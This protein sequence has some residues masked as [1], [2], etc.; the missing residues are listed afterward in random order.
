VP[1]ARAVFAALL[2]CPQGPRFA[3]GATSDAAAN[4]AMIEAAKGREQGQGMLPNFIVGDKS[5][6]GGRPRMLQLLLEAATGR[7]AVVNT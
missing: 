7:L 2:L 5:T 6:A 1:H 4:I 3:Q